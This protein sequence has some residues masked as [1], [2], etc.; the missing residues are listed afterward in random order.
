MTAGNSCSRGGCPR[1]GK[2]T[3]F[4]RFMSLRGRPFACPGCGARLVLPKYPM[5]LGVLAFLIL[6]AAAKLLPPLA[7]VALFAIGVVAEWMLC[8]ICLAD[9]PAGEA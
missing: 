3:P 8:R 7:V 5:V 1:C 2:T 4:A 9:D 6:S